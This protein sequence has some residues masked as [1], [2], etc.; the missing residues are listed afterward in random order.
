MI[1]HGSKSMSA[2]SKYQ[3]PKLHNATWPGLVGKGGPDAEPV[4]DFE[5]MS[6]CRFRTPTS[7]RPMTI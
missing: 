7:I 5:T 3:Y 1:F 6:S 2:E 4:I